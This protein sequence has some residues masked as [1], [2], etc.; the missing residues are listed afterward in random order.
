MTRSWWENEDLLGQF[1]A[2]LTE[3][4]RELQ[5]LEPAEAAAAT[6]LPEEPPAPLPDVG[7]RQLVEAFTALR[8]E[9]KLQTKSSR[10]L[11]DSVQAALDGLE[12]ARRQFQAA[13]SRE[14]EAVEWV[15]WPLVEALVELDEALER[16]A[17]A[18][19]ATHQ[20]MTQAVPQ[21]LRAS[22]AEQF[23]RLPAWRRWLARPWQ[24]QVM[25][26]VADT[27]TRISEQEFVTLMEG[28]Q[29]M[30]RRLARSFER[31]GLER[32][33]CQGETVDPSRM[34]VVELVE[35]P[36]AP[37]ETVIEELRPGY[38][39]RER[40]VRYAEVRAVRHPPAEST[41]VYDE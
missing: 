29:L 19:A 12:A 36:G 38:V 1:R 14:Q 30:Q 4:G 31:L 26:H 9:L 39:W 24:D 34:T 2:W 21:R 40:V 15:A 27:L 8:H 17:R 7:L 23:G 37:A 5:T 22:L 25:T 32:I 16:G 28:Y 33:R 6:Q 18:F 20:Q 41:V 11:E 13:E 10:G 35:A 3:T